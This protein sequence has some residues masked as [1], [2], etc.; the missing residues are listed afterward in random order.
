MKLS[1]EKGDNRGATATNIIGETGPLFVSL[2]TNSWSKNPDKKPLILRL[3]A[4]L[5]H[6]PENKP[7]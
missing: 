3:Y 2:S 6:I 4:E 7:D 5:V 1:V